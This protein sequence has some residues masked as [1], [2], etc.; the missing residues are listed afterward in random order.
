MCCEVLFE[1]GS[2]CDSIPQS[3]LIAVRT[4]QADVKA[5]SNFLN[6]QNAEQLTEGSPVKVK[7]TDDKTYS[8]KVLSTHYSP[9]YT[10]SG[11]NNLFI[12]GEPILT[13]CII[14]GQL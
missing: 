8:A 10:V 6:L 7:W 14:I 3:D 1:D 5:Q 12:T 9:C 4:V 11:C 13:P 2:T